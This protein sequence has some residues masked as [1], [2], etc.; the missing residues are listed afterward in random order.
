MKYSGRGRNVVSDDIV[1]E[2]DRGLFKWRIFI[3]RRAESVSLWHEMFA[4]GCKAYFDQDF[5]VQAQ[6]RIGTG[7]LSGMVTSQDEHRFDSRE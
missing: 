6:G 7:D 2:H 4:D 1:I 5:R 3:V